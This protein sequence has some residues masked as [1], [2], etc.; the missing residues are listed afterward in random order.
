MAGTAGGDTGNADRSDGAADPEA[1]RREPGRID[2]GGG[3]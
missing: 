1:G 3:S 2:E